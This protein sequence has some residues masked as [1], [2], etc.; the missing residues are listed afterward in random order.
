MIFSVRMSDGGIAHS[1]SNPQGCNAL[2]LAGHVLWI[3]KK[4]LVYYGGG[5]EWYTANG[6]Y[7]D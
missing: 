4:N 3:N 5:L 2:F 1:P 7:I 6:N